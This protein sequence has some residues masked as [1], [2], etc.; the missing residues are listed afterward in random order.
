[1]QD[2]SITPTPGGTVGGLLTQLNSTATGFGLYGQF[3]L[4][5]TGAVVFT[6]NAGSGYSVDPLSDTTQRNGTG[7]SATA[8]FGIGAQ[9]RGARA[10][11]FTV[12]PAL[13]QNPNLLAVG[14]VNTA[15]VPPAASLPAGDTSG[16]DAISQAG[17]TLTSFLPAGSS[18]AQSLSVSDYAAALAA[19]IGSKAKAA[20]SAKTSAAATAQTA[21]TRLNASE[22]VNIDEELVNLTTYQQAYNASSRLI[23]AARDMFDTLLGMVR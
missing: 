23:I 12:N 5:A 11:G 8:F 3:S 9:N 10:S 14:T 19:R 18:P 13:L 16:L 6:P 4:N 7:A 21:K 20:D 17:K 22:G 15:A 2:I 1:V